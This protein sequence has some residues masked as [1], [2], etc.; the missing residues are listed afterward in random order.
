M[1]LYVRTAALATKMSQTSRGSTVGKKI[2]K[3]FLVFKCQIFGS[4]FVFIP[5]LYY[6][7]TFRHDH[8][9]PDLIRVQAPK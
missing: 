2:K 7:Q 5:W 3:M 1:P 4:P 6:K 9:K 8:N